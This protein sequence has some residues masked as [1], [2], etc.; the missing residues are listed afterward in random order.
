MMSNPKRRICQ[1]QCLMLVS[2]CDFTLG[3]LKSGEPCVK[4]KNATA[5]DLPITVLMLAQNTERGTSCN[6]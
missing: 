5:P 6:T 2:N 3:K 1:L 4:P